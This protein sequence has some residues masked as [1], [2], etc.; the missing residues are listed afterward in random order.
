MAPTR[1]LA[2]VACS[3][4]W[5]ELAALA[6]S[7]PNCYDIRFLPQGLHSD[8]A[9]LR[10]GLQAAVDAAGEGRSPSGAAGALGPSAWSAAPLRPEAILVGYGL[11]SNGLVG[12]EAR[13]LPLVIPR[14]HDC[15]TL[16]LGSKERYKAIFDSHPGTYWYTPGWIETGLQPGPEREA[17]LRA[18]YQAR[19]GEEGAEALMD[20]EREWMSRYSHCAYVSLGGFPEGGYRDY[21]KACASHLGW[22]WLEPGG[23][24]GLLR[25][26]LA[27]EWDEERFLVVPPGR[28]VEASWDEGVIRL[29]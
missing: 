23:D 10:D 21:A 3:V 18:D 4:L 12:L 6:A 9:R 20:Y 14:A 27:G 15:I 29:A 5:R 2:V 28:R 1:R 11:C 26:F 24:A 17:A 8:P 16:F 22:N 7:I 13:D 19:Y 25:A